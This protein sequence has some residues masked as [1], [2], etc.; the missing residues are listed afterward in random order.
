MLFT[1]II[2]LYWETRTFEQG[3]ELFNVRAGDTD[4]LI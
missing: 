4:A 1:E 3:A 2:A